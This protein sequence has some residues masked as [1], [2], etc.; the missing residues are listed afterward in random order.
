MAQAKTGDKSS[1]KVP[2]ITGGGTL[3]KMAGRKTPKG[4]GKNHNMRTHKLPCGDFVMMPSYQRPTTGSCPT[5]KAE[6]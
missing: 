6:Y 5:C 1:S 2:L 3:A 4:T